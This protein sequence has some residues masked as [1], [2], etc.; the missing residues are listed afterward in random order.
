MLV[1]NQTDVLDSLS[2]SQLFVVVYLASTLSAC[3][4]TL[5]TIGR[6]FS[7][8]YALRMA[9]RQA[10]TSVVSSLALAWTP[11]LLHSIV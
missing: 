10:A 11:L 7:W 6:E 1:L 2:I 8:R 5:W 4:V 3:M 9:G